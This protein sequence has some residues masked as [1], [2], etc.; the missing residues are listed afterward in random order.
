MKYILLG[1]DW[2]T[3]HGE[4]VGS[5]T[6]KMKELGITLKA[7]YYTQGQFDF[8]DV[9]EVP[10]PESLLTFTVWYV[11]QGFSHIQSMPAFDP[12]TMARATGKV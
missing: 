7:V 1:T 6:A 4:R 11:S 5:A 10:E 2:A 8:V 3:R 12:E 9:V